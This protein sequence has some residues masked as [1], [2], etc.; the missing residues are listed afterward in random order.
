MFPDH[1]ITRSSGN[2]WT[3]PDIASGYTL[4]EYEPD[5]GD[6]IAASDLAF[7]RSGA[8]VFELAALGRA[9]VLVPYP[10]ATADHQTANAEW[11]A[12]AGA[13]VVVPDDELDADR[14]LAEVSSILG[15]ANRLEA[16]SEA[17]Q[18]S[19]PAERGKRRRG[20][21]PG[22]DRGRIMSWDDAPGST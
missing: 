20:R 5:M 17:S 7:A 4:L 18:G 9:A 16:M 10:Y 12:E 2:G 22:A 19:G 8:S 3:P 15:D 14:L 1:A 13:A 6:G 11:M 21:S